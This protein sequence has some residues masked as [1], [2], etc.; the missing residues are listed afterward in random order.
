MNQPLEKQPGVAGRKAA[1]D[2]APGEFA[3]IPLAPVSKMVT[4]VVVKRAN[5]I[6]EAVPL[7]LRAGDSVEINGKVVLSLALVVQGV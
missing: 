3:P 6:E 4:A 7:I 5:G 1:A 2:K